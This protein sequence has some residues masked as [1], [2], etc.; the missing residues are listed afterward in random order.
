MKL[1]LD[2]GGQPVPFGPQTQ[3]LI[4]ASYS[5]D[6]RWVAGMGD[7]TVNGA[8]Q[9]AIV[10]VDSVSG[11]IH[12]KYPLPKDTEANTEGG[13]VIGWAPDGKGVL[14]LRST[15]DVVNLW[16]QPVDMILPD[17]QPPPTQ[18]T[19]YPTGRIFSFAFSPDGK[20]IALSRGHASTDAV[21]ISHFI[22]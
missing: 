6:G 14:F 18:I 4:L 12:A 22:H 19:N 17:S 2:S 5:P 11:S 21:L 16:V 3:G 13:R 7:A 1:N 20:S 8:T 9:N 15:Q 10:I